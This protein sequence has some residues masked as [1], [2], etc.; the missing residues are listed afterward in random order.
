MYLPPPL[1]KLREAVRQKQIQRD[2][3][4]EDSIV[5]AYGP[6]EIDDKAISGKT[7]SVEPI[8][9]DDICLFPY[10]R[11]SD[12]DTATH[13]DYGTLMRVLDAVE[14]RIL[15]ELGTAHGNTTANLCKRFADLRVV[16]VDAPKNMLTGDA[17]TFALTETEIGRVYRKHI[18]TNQVTQ[19]FQ[20]TLDLKF[21][22]E[23]SAGSADVAIIDAC[24]DTDYVIND[25]YKVKPFV[26]ENGVILFHDTH[27]SMEGHLRGSFVA[28]SQL[29]KS[30]FDI[31]HI[32]NTWWGIWFNGPF[33]N[34]PDNVTK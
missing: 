18:R 34:S 25:F 16:T 27:P 17:T 29:R 31:R 10:K 21:G 3:R 2:R 1:R 30:G 5:R 28:C 9:F 11:A 4:Q 8:I 14:P 6:P 7:Y 20:N 12:R 19:L 15:I 26:R 32:R 24:H 33:P 23:L 22:A 13:D